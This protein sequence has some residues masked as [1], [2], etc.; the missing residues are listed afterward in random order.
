MSYKYIAYTEAGAIVKGT[1][2]APTEGMA[3]QA[4]MHSGYKP[5]SLK[6]ARPAFS[7]R[8]SMPSFFRVKSQEV[9]TFSRQLATLVE[10][11]ITA[12]NALQLLR[13]Q[14]KNATFREILTEVINDLRRGSSLAD[15]IAKHPNVFPPIYSRMVKISEQ[16]GQLEDSL[17]QTA[18]YMERQVGLAKKVQRVMIYPAF[19]LIL[20]SGVVAVM[21]TFTLPPLIEMFA[22][23]NTGLPI[24]TRI[25]LGVGSFV[26]SNMLLL[27][28]FLVMFI[29]LSVMF[30]KSTIGRWY[31]DKLLLRLPLVGPIVTLRETSHFSRTTSLLLEAGLTMPETMDLTIQT[32]RNVV[33]RE[34]LKEVQIEIMKGLGISGPMASGNIFPPIFVQMVKVGEQ[35]GTLTIEMM[36]M[37]EQYEQEV[38]DRVNSI[39]TMMEPAL[40]VGVGLFV[41]FIA[42][43]VIMPIYNMMGQ[44]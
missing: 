19:I 18:R 33:I 12:I 35:T 3:K 13:D 30:V 21:V 32:T 23:F 6:A 42:V 31:I 17:R 14:M 34:K 1:I 41:A 43:A 2:D 44:I 38:D 36:T 11:G 10:R 9:I 24:L 20:G 28:V 26:S 40:L 27:L 8:R 22:Q 29:G 39:L 15:A 37:A 5:L 4:L 16:T 25:L 7:L